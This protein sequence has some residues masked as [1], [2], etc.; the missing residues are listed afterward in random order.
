MEIRVG[1][2]RKIIVDSKIDTLNVNAT[3]EN[4]S[5]DADALIELFKLLVPLNTVPKSIS[6]SRKVWS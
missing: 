5:S 6:G 2:A 3:T 1:I 4:V